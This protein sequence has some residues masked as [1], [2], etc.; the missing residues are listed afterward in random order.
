MP[1]RARRSALPRVASLAPL[2]S[3]V[4]DFGPELAR[5]ER[6][7]EARALE[8]LATCRPREPLWFMTDPAHM[9]ADAGGRG[10][11]GD[12]K[13][14]RLTHAFSVFDEEIIRREGTSGRSPQQQWF[15][16]EMTKAMLPQL[17]KGHFDDNIDK[18]FE[19]FACS[20][21]S[22]Y[23]IIMMARRKGKS[24]TVSMFVAAL[25]YACGNQQIA[26]FSTGVRASR[27]LLDI[28]FH[29]VEQLPGYNSSW[30][31]VNNKEDLW[32]CCDGAEGVSKCSSYPSHA[33]VR[34]SERR[35]RRRR[36]FLKSCHPARCRRHGCPTWLA[37]RRY[38]ITRARCCYRPHSP[39]Y[40]LHRRPSALIAVRFRV[41]RSASRSASCNAGRARAKTV[42][43]ASAPVARSML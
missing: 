43:A 40:T 3:R 41:S 25:M 30:V 19:Q 36:P 13:L 24:W 29:F 17:Y 34:S 9:E 10:L 27:K 28:I 1:V 39:L 7:H 16:R 26:I 15:H 37:L 22:P 32:L 6:V 14:H 21:F 5:L 42:A 8:R 31:R 4:S 35:R 38:V 20:A 23:L 18:L 2:P 33:Q 12:A 11:G